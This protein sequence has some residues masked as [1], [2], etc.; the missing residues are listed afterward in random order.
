MKKMLRGAP[1][2]ALV[3]LLV[4]M[5]A[6][7]AVVIVAFLTMIVLHEA[8]HLI[9]AKRAGMKV[10]EFF[11]GF[12]PRVWSFQRGGTEYGLK[13]IPAGGYVRIVG[14]TSL[15]EVDPGDEGRCYRD[16]SLSQRLQVIL[17]GS[18]VH[19]MLAFLLLFSLV[20]VVGYRD[21]GKPPTLTIRSITAVAGEESPAVAAGFRPG[22]TIL[23]MDGVPLTEWAAL[24]RYVRDRPGEEIVFEVERDGE[25]VALTAVPGLVEV[26]DIDGKGAGAVGFLGL[27]AD[28]EITRQNPV[29]GAWTSL[30]GMGSA[31]KGSAEGLASVFTPSGLSSFA[32]EVTGAEIDEEGGAAS[33][34]RFMSPVGFVR[35][36][37][38]AADSSLQDVLALLF[39][40]NV[41]VG[42]F[43]LVPLLPF[44]G[45]HAAIAV[46][47]RV[48]EVRARSE[49]RYHADIGRLMPLTYGVFLVLGT[50]AL[51]SLYLDIFQP[52]AS[53]FG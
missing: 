48:R 24:P 39:S 46:Y 45:G 17:A 44:D 16:K 26:A 11:V 40:V 1:L 38:Q 15:E 6:Q 35:V 27:Q 9:M 14:M 41:F 32:G 52:A 12:G 31:L 29:S 25:R 49:R 28:T 21:P 8:G 13:A 34:T 5:G 4:G 20:S 53:P 42:L 43:N 18:A 19:F 10:T 22:D 33:G 7:T 51:G 37:E 36:A 23:S 47:E 50:M 30:K 3:L 2:I